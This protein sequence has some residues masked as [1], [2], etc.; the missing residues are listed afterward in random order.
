MG[1]DNFTVPGETI[2][3]GLSSISVRAHRLAWEAEPRTDFEPSMENIS[4]GDQSSILSAAAMNYALSMPD[5][6]WDSLVQKG[7]PNL[8][9][10][11]EMVSIGKIYALQ[12]KLLAAQLFLSFFLYSTKGCLKKNAT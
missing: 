12:N 4:F 7:P 5:E 2:A 3:G 9:G 6:M 10:F 11:F 1:C 8:A